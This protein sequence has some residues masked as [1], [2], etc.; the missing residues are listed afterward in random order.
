MGAQQSHEATP[1]GKH[2]DQE[3]DLQEAVDD[4]QEARRAYG[5]FVFPAVMATI[6]CWAAVLLA[7]YQSSDPAADAL[8]GEA[9]EALEP[10]YLYWAIYSTVGPICCC[11]VL[12]IGLGCFLVVRSEWMAKCMGALQFTGAASK[13]RRI[14]RDR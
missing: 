8:M 11:D 9:T 2:V 4:S 10:I 13:L 1:T 5:L 14:L 3:D 12:G 7:R 6:L